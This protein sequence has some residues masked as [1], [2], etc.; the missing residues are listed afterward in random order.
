MNL[1]HKHKWKV[2][3]IHM[4]NKI[5]DNIK[6]LRQLCGL[7]QAD[8]GA[9]FGLTRDN[10][11]SYERG[12]EP[13]I[14]ALSRIVTYFHISF[15]DLIH[16]DIEKTKSTEIITNDLGVLKTKST[17]IITIE[18]SNKNSNKSDTDEKRIKHY[19]TNGDDDLISL[20]EGMNK[21]ALKTDDTLEHQT[22]PLF[23]LEASAGLV[24]LFSDTAS[25]KPV[26]FITIPNLPRCDGAIHVTGDSMYPLLKS[27]DIVLYK[28]IN[29]IQNNIFWGEMYLVSV[30]LEGEE[31][32][33][34]KY[35][36]KSENPD[37]IKLVSHNQHHSD[38]DVHISKVRALAFVKASIRINSM[39]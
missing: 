1:N 20:K 34:V 22:I 13:K 30:D 27:G 24:P 8:F 14:D 31:Y 6:Y 32:I 23:D 26:D 10:I 11:A 36:Q 35:I 21:F 17:E 18:N 19:Q 29:D 4:Q 2:N 15:E 25:Q 28:K 37:Y 7:N 5:S 16:V 12:T 9:K 3:F 38:K 33:T 39:R